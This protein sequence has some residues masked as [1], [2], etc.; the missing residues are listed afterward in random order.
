MMDI[1][2]KPRASAVSHRQSQESLLVSLFRT[3]ARTQNEAQFGSI[4]VNSI[5]HEFDNALQ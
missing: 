1:P 4:F 2:T 5:G 3:A